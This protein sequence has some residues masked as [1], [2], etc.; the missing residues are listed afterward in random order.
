M[1]WFIIA[2]LSALFSAA[3]ALSQ[4]KILFKID[5]L[6]F[7][8]YLSLI[9]FLFSIPFFIGIN[10][11]E[12][13]QEALLILY[14]KSILGTFA[15]LF[16]M[17]VLKNFEISKGLPFMVLTPGI[18]AVFAFIF[19]HDV[20]S[21]NEISGIILLMLGTYLLE[22]KEDAGKI[23]VLSFNNFFAKIKN[24]KKYKYIFF[25][26]ILF[27][28]SSILDRLLLTDYKF[29]P[30]DFMA[31]QQLF[32]AVNF[33]IIY[34]I[35]NKKIDLG[36]ISKNK[37]TFYWIL[38]IGILTIGYRYTQIEA[39]KLAP[40]ALVLAVKR[41][42]VFFSVIIGGKIFEEKNL[43]LRAAA[44]AIMVAGTLLLLKY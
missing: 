15:F 12:I 26:L 24:S 31:F 29:K 42:S 3:A 5:A 9:G 43:L 23:K 40:V 11:S 2:L 21:F 39:I 16:V 28:V 10:L 4:K 27:T 18:V 36:F 17:L 30:F 19:L 41:I 20:L 35:I 13:N 7:S 8:F 25:A 38:L 22:L 33:T 32:F 34:L 14:I 37:N 1:N 44:T 6:T